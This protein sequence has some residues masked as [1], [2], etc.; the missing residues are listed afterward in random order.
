MDF[1]KLFSLE[2]Y[3]ELYMWSHDENRVEAGYFSPDS[4]YWAI[5]DEFGLIRIFNVES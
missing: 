5:G 2:T 4:V 1:L 3:E